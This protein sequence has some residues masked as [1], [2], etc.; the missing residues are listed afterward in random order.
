MKPIPRYWALHRE[1]ASL[2]GGSTPLSASGSSDLSQ[3]D[4]E[5]DARERFAALVAAGGPRNRRDGGE[6]YPDRRRPEQL[7]EEIFSPDGELIAATTRNR[8]G[9]TVLNTDAL[10]IADIDLGEEAAS[11]TGGGLLSRL[12]GRARPAPASTE[13]PDRR[14][15]PGEGARGEEHRRIL[16][17]IGRFCA[18]HPEVGV[19]TY[20]TR[21]GFRLLLTGT[22]AKPDS[23]EAREL[24]EGLGSD[25]LYTLLCRVH[26]T[27]RARLTPKPWRLGLSAPAL[28]GP[29]AV[30][31]KQWHRWVSD[32]EAACGQVAVCRFLGSAGPAPGPVEQQIIDLHDHAVRH[33]SGLRLA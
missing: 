11:A 18:E 13:D 16:A 24:L 4:A 2:P 15:E 19:R 14:G 26:D 9:A 21:N 33:E 8:Y 22:G 29:S 12:F 20:R 28:V 32:Y 6:Y 3:E 31:T 1:V 23:A 27:Y 17:R 7:L 5:R 25:E 30:G 10:L